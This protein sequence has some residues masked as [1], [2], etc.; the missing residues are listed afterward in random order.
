LN[1]SASVFE[2][3]ITLILSIWS[4]VLRRFNSLLHR[5]NFVQ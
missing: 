1:A 2:D 3:D 5:R 4:A